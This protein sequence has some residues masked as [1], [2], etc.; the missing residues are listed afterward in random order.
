MA[1]WDIL[2]GVMQFIVLVNCWLLGRYSLETPVFMRNNSWFNTFILKNWPD[3][4]LSWIASS[5]FDFHINWV[6]SVSA[7]NIYEPPRRP[8][9]VIV[10]G[11]LPCHWLSEILCVPNS[12]GSEIVAS[13]L[14]RKIDDL[15]LARAD[16]LWYVSSFK[17]SRGIGYI[18]ICEIG[19]VDMEKRWSEFLPIYG[20]ETLCPASSPQVLSSQLWRVAVSGKGRVWW[21][22]YALTIIIK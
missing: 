1:V 16:T 22:W 3:C 12:D 7:Y 21:W 19:G 8:S 20:H 18:Y 5:N 11:N 15:C 4:C 6:S 10:K 14:L 2:K 9:W 13:F 17:R